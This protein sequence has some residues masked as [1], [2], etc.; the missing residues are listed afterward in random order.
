MNI[1]NNKNNKLRNKCVSK[2]CN[3]ITQQT[4]QNRSN[5][6]CFW[7]SRLFVILAKIT[8]ANALKF[9]LRGL[10]DSVRAAAGHRVLRGSAGM[11][12][13]QYS[14]RNSLAIGPLG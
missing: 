12:G 14:S 7:K 1:I 11:Q 5:I 2:V 3:I 4:G 13:I 9:R 8:H 6:A 10:D